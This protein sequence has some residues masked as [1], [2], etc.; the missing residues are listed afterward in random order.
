MAL[1]GEE[2]AKLHWGPG[3]VSVGDATLDLAEK[4]RSLARAKGPRVGGGGGGG[5]GSQSHEG[6]RSYTC[7]VCGFSAKQLGHLQEHQRVHTSERPFP[8]EF[9]ECV[10]RATTSGNLK[11]HARVHT[12]VLPFSCDVLGCGYSTTQS[13]H[14]KRH[15]RTQHKPLVAAA[16]T[17][18]DEGLQTS[19]PGAVHSKK[20][21]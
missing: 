21:R 17:G 14:L 8:C 1:L 16:E 15:T 9:P 10:Y 11:R 3:E 19:L 20:Q 13:C 4:L 12:G 5:G 18:E 7:E 6:V 2:G